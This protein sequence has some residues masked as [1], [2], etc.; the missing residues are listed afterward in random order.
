MAIRDEVHF[1]REDMA[2]IKQM[3]EELL[4]VLSAMFAEGQERVKQLNSKADEEK[5]R[6]QIRMG[7]LSERLQ[8]GFDIFST[9]TQ[10][11][12]WTDRA[13]GA[14][15]P[16]QTTASSTYNPKEHILANVVIDFVYRWSGLAC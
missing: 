14:P 2:A 10:V 13:T 11:E 9:R 8:T 5:M 7:D 15:K 4:L 12:G 6:S 3:Q 1:A 16:R